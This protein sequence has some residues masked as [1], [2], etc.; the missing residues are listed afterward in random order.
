MSCSQIFTL[1][2][3]ELV[4]EHAIDNARVSGDRG[5]QKGVRAVGLKA[6][7]HGEGSRGHELLGVVS[8]LG[9]SD[10]EGTGLVAW[11]KITYIAFVTD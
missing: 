6:T 1:G 3:L 4:R 2:E 5:G 10:G 11:L 9:A 8:E 7:G